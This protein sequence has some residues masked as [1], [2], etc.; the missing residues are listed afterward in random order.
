M[1]KI[2]GKKN[3]MKIK[4]GERCRNPPKVAPIFFWE[5]VFPCFYFWKNMIAASPFFKSATQ[6]KQVHI[7]KTV[8]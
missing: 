7:R 6:I 3:Q 2:E 4:D 1:R 5:S 8:A